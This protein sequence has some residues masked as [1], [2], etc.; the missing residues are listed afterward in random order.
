MKLSV[1]HAELWESFST[2]M[3][4]GRDAECVEALGRTARFLQGEETTSVAVSDGWLGSSGCH[5]GYS[6]ALPAGWLG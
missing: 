1:Q 3:G 4:P 5:Q 6:S 2:Q